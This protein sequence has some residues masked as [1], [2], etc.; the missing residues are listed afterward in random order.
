[1]AYH[2]ADAE[3][4]SRWQ[5]SL[6][7]QDA[8]V[9]RWQRA[10]KLGFGPGSSIYGSAMVLEPVSVAGNTWIGPNTLL[11][12]SGGGIVIGE[13]CSIAAGVHI[14]TH[15]TVR[16]ALSGGV[17]ERTVGPVRVG[18]RCYIGP[19]SIVVAGVT[20]GRCSVIG[21]NSVVLQTIPERTVVAGSPAR[22]IGCVEGEGE[23]VRIV[24]ARRRPC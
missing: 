14:Y 7:L 12:G 20:I 11:D 23:D 17:A 3:L 5:R 6:P 18:D 4:R 16:W 9:D 13:Y 2:A 21:A 10:A 15:D 24:T 19:M 22:V 1:M 8:L